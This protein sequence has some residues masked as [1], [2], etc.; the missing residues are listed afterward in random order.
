VR[1]TH[2]HHALCPYTASCHNRRYYRKGG[3][4]FF[5]V[6]THHRQP[7]LLNDNIRTALRAFI[8]EVRQILTY[9]FGE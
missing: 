6:V 8:N 5:T 1:S 3:S 2:R 7:I 9:D 4:Y